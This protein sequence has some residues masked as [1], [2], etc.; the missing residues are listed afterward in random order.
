MKLIEVDKERYRK[1]LNRVLVACALCL[2]ISSLLLSQFLIYLFPDPSG[3]HFHWNA[4]GVLVSAAL[5]GL[6]LSKCRHH[7]YLTEVYYVWQLKQVLNKITRKMRKLEA[8]AQ[9]GNADAMLAL[10]YSYS[11]SRLLWQLDDNTIIMDE[12][13]VKQTTL[14]NLAEQHN[15]KLNLDDFNEQLLKQF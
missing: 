1:H 10:Q 12:L 15:V 3:S 8:A 4:I 11:G 13:A 5:V 14:N 9:Q 7:S 6:T 2:A